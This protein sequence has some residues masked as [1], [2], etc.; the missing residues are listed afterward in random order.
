MSS[1]ELRKNVAKIKILDELN[2]VVIGLDRSHYETL[3]NYYGVLAK[4][5]FF[6]RQ[7]KLGRWD[8]KV[9]FFSKNGK[10][11]IHFIP[12]IVKLLRDMGYDDVEIIDNR[13]PLYFD[14]PEVD[15]QYFID[16]S[17]ED[18]T[19]ITLGKHQVEGI[20]ALTRDGGGMLLAGTGAGKSIVCA[21]LVK[22]HNEHA[23][24]RCLVIVPTKDLIK[25]T[26][27]DIAHFGID[28]GR[29]YGD[30]KE[31]NRQNLVSTWQSLQNIPTLL[32]MFDIIIVDECHG[33]RG[34]ILKN[35]ILEYGI[36]SKGIFGVTGTLPKD[37][38]EAL[39]VQYVL[40][41]VKYVIPA[42]ELIESGWLAQLDLETWTLTEDLT[43]EWNYY[44]EKFPEKAE[45]TNYKSFKRDFFQ[46]YAEEK[47][48]LHNNKNRI[49]FIAESVKLSVAEYG[50]AFVLVN[51]VPFG[52]K[53]SKE[54]ENSIFVDGTDH[55]DIR[56][57]VYA[58]FGER[59][60]VVVIATAQLA[61]TGLNIKRIFSL[62]LVDLGKSFIQIIQSIG[63]GLR[64]A[65]DKHKVYVFDYASDL[66]Y[67]AK[68]SKERKKYYKEQN[69]A[70]KQKVVDYKKIIDNEN[71]L[72]VY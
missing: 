59:D 46:E 9:R 32:G 63:R 27:A 57:K 49:Q 68:H 34:N 18:G 72:V 6:K 58:L 51:S 47:K 64:K 39:S 23:G 40:G 33:V 48:Y 52:K 67:G 29:F 2:A 69:Y 26:S 13:E 28:V 35:M 8:G 43:S 71:D 53:L 25:Q 5:Y 42:S 14:I 1:L 7:Y 4:D 62:H 37:K 60:D 55:S 21:A 38:S 16:Y 61:S 50:N 19:P 36:K 44:K 22:L 65:K 54:I 15:D 17:D 30:E 11:S 31:P 66:K 24:A 41:T 45:Q 56:K 12:E 3:Y 70:F 10:T 20:N